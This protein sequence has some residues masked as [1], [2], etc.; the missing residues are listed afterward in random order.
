ML[1]RVSFG[2]ICNR[3]LI[4]RRQFSTFPSQ[5][6][7]ST[8]SL[9]S[10]PPLSGYTRLP[11]RALIAVTGKDSTTFLQGLVTQ[12]LLTARN[13]PVPKSGFYAAFLNAPGRVLHDVF[14]YPVPPNDSYNGTSDLAYLI[15]VDKNE[16]QTLLK[17][18]K[19]H[20]LRSKLAFR[21]MDEGELCVFSLWNEED[22]GQLTECDFQ[23]DNGK[24]PPFTCVDT[25]APGFG[26]RFLAPEKVVNEQPI[27]PGEMVDF[28]TYNLRRILYGVPE[29]QSEIIR[30]SALPMECNMDIMGGIDFHKGCY[31]GQELT[32]RTHHRGV[33]RKRILPVQLYD[34]DETM[35]KT[36]TPYYSSESKL[37]LPPAGANIAKV[38]SKKGRSAGKFLSGVGNI[39]LALCRL[40]MMTDIA[41]T[42]E[43]SQYGPDQEFKISWEADPEAGVEKT[44]ELKVKALV[45]PWMRDFI[46]SGGA[47]KP[48]M[49]TPKSD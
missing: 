34:I 42:D 31:T 29:G 33:V 13:T 20:K 8:P 1:S 18:M 40:E 41:F 16:V 3:C 22:A 12:N 37:V 28:A 7:Q 23:L 39:G 35:P 15:E 6:Q 5:H 49:P 27:M 47:K 21:A 36:E 25:R 9:P 30:E 48:T 26:F 10:L 45:P 46:V 2:S 32:I 4:S 24:S 44:G 43:S 17:H 19:K 38:S 14:I 11:T